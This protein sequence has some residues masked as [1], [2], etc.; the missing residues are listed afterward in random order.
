MGHTQPPTPVQVDNST[1]LGIVNGTIKQRK[2]K[3]MDMRFYWIRDRINQDQFNIHWKPGSTNM[4]DYFTKT[5]PPA[6]HTT[7]RPSYLHVAR[8]GKPSTLQG[9]VNLT[10]FAN[11][12]MHPCAPDKG[13]AHAYKQ[14]CKRIHR[15]S[16]EDAHAR[17]QNCAHLYNYFLTCLNN[18]SETQNQKIV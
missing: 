16:L 7:L 11:H 10:L 18:D 13:S 2:S 9:C 17:S 1:A 4:G 14:N 6:H 8:H 12:P 5:F 15:E 3:E